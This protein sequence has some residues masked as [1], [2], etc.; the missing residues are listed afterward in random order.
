MVLVVGEP[1]QPAPL[2]DSGRVSRGGVRTLTEDLRSTLQE[3][4]DDA[5]DRAGTPN[6]G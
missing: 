1:M 4:F 5:Q 6:R 2:K 3:L